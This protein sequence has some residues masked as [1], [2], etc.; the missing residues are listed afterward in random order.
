M[1]YDDDKNTS[2][3]DFINYLEENGV[4][5]HLSQVLLKLFKEKEKPKDAI[6][7]IRDNL[8]YLENDVSL[9]DLKHENLYLRQENQRLTKK[10]E[11]LNE[12]LQ[13]LL[14]NPLDSKP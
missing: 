1:N 6:K 5:N 11:E 14:N 13:K 10:F 8:Q 4:I 12:T 7:F 2:K 3:D 9:D